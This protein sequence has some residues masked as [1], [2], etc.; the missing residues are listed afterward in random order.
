MPSTVSVGDEELEGRS[1][2]GRAAADVL[3]TEDITYGAGGWQLLHDVMIDKGA[4]TA[5]SH[6]SENEKQ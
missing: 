5:T 6:A 4:G 3:L 1:K 2:Y